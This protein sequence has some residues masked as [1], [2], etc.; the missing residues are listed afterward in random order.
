[1][2]TL[3]GSQLGEVMTFLGDGRTGVERSSRLHLVPKPLSSTLLRCDE[4]SPS[5][6]SRGHALAEPMIIT[7]GSFW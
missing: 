4:A 2:V 3:F 1:M 7:S 6:T 5:Q